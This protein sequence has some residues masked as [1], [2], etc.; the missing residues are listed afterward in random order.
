[1]SDHESRMFIRKRGRTVNT[2]HTL[3]NSSR[4]ETRLPLSIQGCL[5]HHR[6]PSV[7]E[8]TSNRTENSPTRDLVDTYS[9]TK[10]ARAADTNATIACQQPSTTE[11]FQVRNSLTHTL[12]FRIPLFLQPVTPLTSM[13]NGNYRENPR[14][15]TQAPCHEAN[16]SIRMARSLE[17]L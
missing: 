9:G 12:F 3:S 5:S 15:R 4:P 16:G 10:S 14:T 6:A 8:C 17:L 2:K 11:V 1:M 13:M 7:S